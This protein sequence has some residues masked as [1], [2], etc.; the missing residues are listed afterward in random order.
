MT[1]SIDCAGGDHKN[2]SL[3]FCQC[4]CHTG[5]NNRAAAAL[6]MFALILNVA[7]GPM[8]D[9]KKTPGD[10]L[11]T[12]ADVVCKVGYTKTVRNV[13]DSL[14][15]RVLQLYGYNPKKRPRMEIDHLI[16]LELGGSNDITNLWPEPYEPRPGAHEKDVFENYLHREVCAGRMKLTN[17]QGLIA[18]DWLTGYKKYKSE[19]KKK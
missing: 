14:K 2:C 17:A 11:T 4:W 1:H 10:V 9:S 19:R 6:A 5:M 12:D 7:A 3:D 13:P 18:H 15:T 16:S 8:P